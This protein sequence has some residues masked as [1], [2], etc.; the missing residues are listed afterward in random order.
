MSECLNRLTFQTF[1]APEDE[2]RPLT[3]NKGC[4]LTGVELMASGIKTRGHL[5]KLGRIIDTSKFRRSLP[6]IKDPRGRLNLVERQC[7]L[8]LVFCLDDLGYPLAGWIRDYLSGD[9]DADAEADYASFTEMYLHR[10]AAELAA[11]IL[12]GRKL[13]LGCIWS[14]SNQPM[15]Y[16]GI[17]V[18]SGEGGD[19]QYSQPSELVFTSVRKSDPESQTY[20]ID[21]HVSLLVDEETISGC[22]LPQLRVRSWLLGMYFFDGC[23]RIE[24]VFPWPR[25]LE[26]MKPESKEVG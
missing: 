1:N 17:F 24:V 6:R 25:A 11:A 23:P 15:S 12:A 3:F 20:D 5:W 4:R 19:R 7:L 21:H 8:Q 16:S 10:M 26:F 22:S 9:A 18:W 14:K 2:T 13:R